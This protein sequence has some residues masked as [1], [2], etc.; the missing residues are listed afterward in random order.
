[1]IQVLRQTGWMVLRQLRNLMRQP[2][3][4]ALMVIQPLI[5]LLLYGQLFSRVGQLRGGASSYVEFLAP[6]IICM[7][8]FF[9]GSWS[10]M[11][12][13]SD[14]DR[15]VIDRF[16]AAPASRF[17]II[18][19]QVV[20][21]GITAII[22]ALLLLLVGLALDVRVHGGALGWVV[23]CAAAALLA[24]AFAGLSHGIALLVRKEASMIAAA[25]F[26]GLPLMFISSILIP[27]QSMPHWIEVVSRFNPVNWG[28]RAA[29]NAIVTGGN[30][31]HSGV[32]LLMLIAA[33]AATSLFATWCFRS[34]QRSI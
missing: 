22:Q 26:I 21:A 30:W 33:T 31:G 19:S 16:L 5:W 17:A 9:G 13:I 6:G 32:Y 1:M 3:W 34:Y 28:V 2:I 15:H 7:N 14:L 20:R 11:A 23:V 27:T 4:I 29:R 24:M 25:N 8:S 10:G 18:L 12:M